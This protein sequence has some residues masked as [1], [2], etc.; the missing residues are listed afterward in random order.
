MNLLDSANF[1][2][3]VNTFDDRFFFFGSTFSVS[4]R[5]LFVQ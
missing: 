2:D 3:S 5:D 4:S 1:L